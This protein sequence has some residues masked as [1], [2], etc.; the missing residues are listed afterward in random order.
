MGRN[1]SFG[2]LHRSSTGVRFGTVGHLLLEPRKPDVSPRK[3][4]GKPLAAFQ[5]VQKKLADAVTA[6]TIGLLASL[7][8]GRLKDMGKWSPDMVSMMK[9]NN[10]AAAVLHSRVLLEILGGNAC[11]DEYHIGRHAVNLHVCSTYEGTGV[12]PRSNWGT[13]ADAITFRTYTVYFSALLSAY[14]LILS[15]YDHR[16]SHYRYFRLLLEHWTRWRYQVTRRRQPIFRHMGWHH[17]ALH[18]LLDLSILRSQH[19]RTLY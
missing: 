10:C 2:G 5:L 16:Q 11:A 1:G 15:S 6:N 12:S 14:Q 18:L 4:F 9:R 17:E 8:L 13:V 19:V 3:Q 7:Q